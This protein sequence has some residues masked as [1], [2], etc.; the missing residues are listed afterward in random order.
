MK[1]GSGTGYTFTI[2]ENEYDFQRA[3]LTFARAFGACIMQRDDPHDVLPKYRE[4][5]DFYSKNVADSKQQLADWEA[6]SD[7]EKIAEINAENVRA[8]AS[9]EETIREYTATVE[10]FTDLKQKIEQWVPPTD[11]HIRLKE[12]ALEQINMS[13][14]DLNWVQESLQE[15]LKKTDA[16]FQRAV[17]ERGEMLQRVNE[18]SES[19][20]QEELDRV[21]SSNKWLSDLYASIGYN[22]PIELK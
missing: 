7:A 18:R 4:V 19:S 15:R 16:D 9:Y 8:I 20:Y 21:N 14:P 10:F 6:K 12:F 13:M 11:E 1:I 3:M 22:V 2:V 5:S 17:Q